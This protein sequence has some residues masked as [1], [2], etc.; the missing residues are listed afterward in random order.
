MLRLI[1]NQVEM[2]YKNMRECFRRIDLDCSGMLSR[3]EVEFALATWRIPAKREQVDKIMADLDRDGDERISFA[4]WCEGLKQAAVQS[5]DVFGRGDAHVT[6]HMRV[7]AGGRVIINDNLSAMP[8]A[9]KQRSAGRPDFQPWR[10]PKASAP[11]SPQQLEGA[12]HAMQDQIYVKFKLLRDA[13]RS[14]DTNHDG[15]LSAAELLTAVRCFNLSIPEEHVMQLARQCDKDGSG[16]IDYN[17]FAAVLKRK[18]ALG[19]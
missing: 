2:R 9:E 7:L 15:K 6:D 3:D 11:A 13:F 17:E 18:D 16:A 8:P 12:V 1:G 19:N 10:L 5:G 14:F 4:E